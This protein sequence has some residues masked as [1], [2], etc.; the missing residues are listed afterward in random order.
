[1]ESSPKKKG[2]SPSLPSRR[3]AE[4]ICSFSS[5][6]KVYFTSRSPVARNISKQQGT[7]AGGRRRRTADTDDTNGPSC[8]CRRLILFPSSF[9]SLQLRVLRSLP[10]LCLSYPALKL[11]FETEDVSKLW[12]TSFRTHRL[13]YLSCCQK[14]KY[15]KKKHG[16]CILLEC[17]RT[18]GG[19]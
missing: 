14:I 11:N 6:G 19:N 7:G 17:G 2:A 5:S 4:S 16:G 18:V 12:C 10:S 8:R 3:Y 1:M 9:Q 15:Q 13:L